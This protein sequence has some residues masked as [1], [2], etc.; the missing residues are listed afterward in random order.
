MQ[1]GGLVDGRINIRCQRFATSAFLSCSVVVFFGLT[2]IATY[3][4]AQVPKAPATA[5]ATD[6]L[7]RANPQGCVTA[8]LQA[9]RRQDYELASRYLDLEYLSETNRKEKGPELAKNLE[10]ALNSAPHFRVLELSRNP[11]GSSTD[12]GNLHVS[13]SPLLARTAKRILSIWNE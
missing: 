7:G 2:S 9:C 13:Q 11:E 5:P 6:K 4:T 3:S 1:D 12:G 8:F 10:A